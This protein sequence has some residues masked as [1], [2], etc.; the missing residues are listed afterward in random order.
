MKLEIA[1]IMDRLGA[2]KDKLL[3]APDELFVL[4]ED[5]IQMCLWYVSSISDFDLASTCSLGATRL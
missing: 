3:L 4:F 5:F 2:D 1:G